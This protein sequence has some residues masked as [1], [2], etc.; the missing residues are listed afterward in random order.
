LESLRGSSHWQLQYQHLVLQMEL[1]LLLEGKRLCPKYKN[2]IV[3]WSLENFLRMKLLK[4]LYNYIQ[5]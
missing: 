2:G 5:Q 4:D 3:E 1:Y